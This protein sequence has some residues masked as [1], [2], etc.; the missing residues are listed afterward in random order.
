MDGQIAD[1]AAV[2][3]GRAL[4]IRPPGRLLRTSEIDLI[5]EAD[6]QVWL[7]RLRAPNPRRCSNPL[8]RLRS[9]VRAPAPPGCRLP[10]TSGYRPARVG[11]ACTARGKFRE[12]D[13]RPKLRTELQL[14]LDERPNRP[15][16]GDNRA[17]FLNAKGGRP[18]HPNG[19]C[20]AG[21]AWPA[22]RS[23][24]SVRPGSSSSCGRCRPASRGRRRSRYGVA[25]CDRTR[26]A[27]RYIRPLKATRQ[28]SGPTL[29]ATAIT[30]PSG[31]FTNSE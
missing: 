26:C 24:R 15:H 16:A 28:P 6:S 9:A 19:R 4:M 29:S 22:G 8:P 1:A 11:C 25:R 18:Q 21:A 20:A 27:M 17:L 10:T 7:P 31:V 14:W 30:R 12:V 23:A 3:G 5:S 13:I 2:A